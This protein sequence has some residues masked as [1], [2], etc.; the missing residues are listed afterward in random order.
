MELLLAFLL[1]RATKGAS[2]FDI[3]GGVIGAIVV[4]AL[5][6]G[7]TAL[8]WH[9]APQAE[10][11]IE[12]TGIANYLPVDDIHIRDAEEGASTI[13]KDIVGITSRLLVCFVAMNIIIF[14]LFALILMLRVF[15]PLAMRAYAALKHR[16]EGCGK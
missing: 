15:V 9:F 16:S 13:V 2:P 14:S 6:S 11:L 7:M 4:I 3:I 12:W 10:H 5:L 8:V 1:G